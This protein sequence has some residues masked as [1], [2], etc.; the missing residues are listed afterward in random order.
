MAYEVFESHSMNITFLQI[1]AK[2]ISYLAKRVTYTMSNNY[3]LGE[4]KK[5]W[6]NNLQCAIC[7]YG[8]THARDAAS[9]NTHRT[10]Q[11]NGATFTMYPLAGPDL[12]QIHGI[13]LFLTLR[14]AAECGTDLTR[15]KTA[16]FRR[17]VNTLSL[18]GDRPKSY[19]S[20]WHHPPPQLIRVGSIWH[21][22]K[23]CSVTT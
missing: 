16:K 17:A 19:L 10:K 2:R 22:T 18:V 5:S 4:W 14:L 8:S 9:Q 23:I 11:S 12:T 6:C 7:L 1:H 3:L 15:W 13:G 20:D 21:A